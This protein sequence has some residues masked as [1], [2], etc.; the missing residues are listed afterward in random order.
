MAYRLIASST[1]YRTFISTIVPPGYVCGHSIAIV[2]I[3]NLKHL[4]FLVGVTNSFVVDYFLRQKVSANVTMFN[5]LET[6]VPRLSS[7]K[8]F[9]EIVRKVAQLVCTTNEFSELKKV[10]GVN[11]ALTSE[12]DI[13]LARA[14]LDVMVAKIYGISKDELAFILEKFPIVDKKQKEL[15]LSQY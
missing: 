14:Q 1:N 8:E 7:G 9:D 5:F 2:K 10:S 15:V 11:Y 3:P 12:N 13:T 6:P 4:S